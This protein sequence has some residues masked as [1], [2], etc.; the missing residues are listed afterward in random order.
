MICFGMDSEG[1]F[2]SNDTDLMMLKN[3]IALS[4]PNENP[5][6]AMSRF[7]KEIHRELNDQ[8]VVERTY[9][10]GHLSVKSTFF[11]FRVKDDAPKKELKEFEC[12][13]TS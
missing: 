3:S 2:L 12:A 6:T 7:R 5:E 13:V 9:K 1:W 4:F 10:A 8:M 11:F